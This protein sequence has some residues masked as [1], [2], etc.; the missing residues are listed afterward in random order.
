MRALCKGPSGGFNLA[1][2]PRESR[3]VERAFGIDPGALAGVV[4]LIG[5]ASK[6][7]TCGAA[8]LDSVR[9]T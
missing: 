3:I 1:R 2:D 5:E 4:A 9:S 8:Q 6:L 7:L